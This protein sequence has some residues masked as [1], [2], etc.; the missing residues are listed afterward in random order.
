MI[1]VDVL[2]ITMLGV[3]TYHDF[4]LRKITLWSLVIL[5]GLFVL[6]GYST[7]STINYIQFTAIN[8]AFILS[9]LLLVSVYFMIKN[10]NVKSIINRYIGAGDILLLSVFCFAFAPLPFV[11]FYIGSLLSI[12]LFYMFRQLVFRQPDG[13]IPLAGFQSLIFIV[14]LLA[15]LLF[16]APQFYSNY[17]ADIQFLFAT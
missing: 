9:Q 4:R 7:L 17:F 13:Y 15:K 1:L 3:I 8:L 2:I 10:R 16:K 6:N 12:L 14:L 5:L 11:V